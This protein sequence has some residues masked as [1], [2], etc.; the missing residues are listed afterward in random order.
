MS[1]HYRQTDIVAKNCE[2]LKNPTSAECLV[3]ATDAFFDQI[4]PKDCNLNHHSI[5]NWFC[6]WLGKD[7]NHK[8]A[9]EIKYSC[10]LGNV[11]MTRINP[12][13][14]TDGCDGVHQLGFPEQI[15]VN[16]GGRIDIKCTPKGCI[17]W[18]INEFLGDQIFFQNLLCGVW[19][20][21]EVHQPDAHS[22]GQES[23]RGK[24][25]L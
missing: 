9:L 13:Q 17:R 3:W 19:L 24:V 7:A 15:K 12:H 6:L 21:G 8:R 10:G 22:H 25:R 18:E 4:L 16:S 14:R 2:H 11:D 1:V 23:L 20:W 5:E